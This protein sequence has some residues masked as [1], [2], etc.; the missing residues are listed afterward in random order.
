MLLARPAVSKRVADRQLT[1]DDP[2]H[3]DD[4]D[5]DNSND[6]NADTADQGPPVR[7]TNA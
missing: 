3:A 5:D 1:S 6:N 7:D 4:S 2:A